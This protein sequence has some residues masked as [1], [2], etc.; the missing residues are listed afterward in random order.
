MALASTSSSSGAEVSVSSLEQMLRMFMSI[1]VTFSPTKGRDQ[2]GGSGGG[3]E[4]SYQPS[5][6]TSALYIEYRLI[7]CP[8]LA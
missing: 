6:V 1:S 5:K 2:M 7:F 4:S 8:L 3:E